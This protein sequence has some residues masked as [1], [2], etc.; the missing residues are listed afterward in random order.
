MSASGR[1]LDGTSWVN[2][3]V[4]AQIC[5]GRRGRFPPPT[6]HCKDGRRH[7]EYDLVS[8]TFCGY[9]FRP[10][11]AYDRKRKRAFTG[12]L[13]AVSPEK[14]TD[15]SRRAASWRLHRRTGSTLDDLAKDVNPVLRGWLNYFTVLYPS[16]V[17]PI[18]KRMAWIFHGR[19][20]GSP[21]AGGQAF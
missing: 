7:R 2:R 17:I 6:R 8:F 13:P 4:H 18:G 15:M 3:E 10:R 12:F 5:G 20:R 16:A 1:Q 14:L 21:V 9:T 11:K 19:D